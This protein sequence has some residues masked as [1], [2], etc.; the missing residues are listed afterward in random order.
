ML[1]CIGFLV[2]F[3]LCRLCRYVTVVCLLLEQHDVLSY[4]LLLSLRSDLECTR[5]VG[6]EAFLRY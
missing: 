6:D 1:L 3:E 5:R 2:S 4:P